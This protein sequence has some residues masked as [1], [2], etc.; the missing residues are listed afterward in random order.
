MKYIRFNDRIVKSSVVTHE[1][2]EDICDA[3]YF[4][5]LRKGS[6]CKIGATWWNYYGCWTSIIDEQG[7]KYDIRPSEVEKVTKELKSVDT[8]EELCNEFVCITNDGELPLLDTLDKIMLYA[9][10]YPDNV[11]NIYGAIW[12]D[13]GLIYVAKMNNEGELELI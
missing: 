7:Q 4:K 2:I 5:V 13:K 11:K 8:I 9:D 1:L 3:G 10:T 12:T 6:L